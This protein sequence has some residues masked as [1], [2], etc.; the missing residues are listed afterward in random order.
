MPPE[1]RAEEY[2]TLLQ[3]FELLSRLNEDKVLN[4]CVFAERR[5]PPLGSC[6]EQILDAIRTRHAI[7]FDYECFR[8]NNDLKKE[9]LEPHLLKESQHRWYV[10]GYDYKARLR[11]FALERIKGIVLSARKFEPKPTEQIV[12]IFDNSFGIWADENIPIEDIVV[13]YSKLDGSFVKS[14][15]LHH[16]Q[17]VI[18]EEEGNTTI[19]FR[20]RITNDFVMELLSRSRSVEIIEPRWLRAEFEKIYRNALRRNTTEL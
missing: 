18:A 5:R 3:S 17:H 7:E 8:D 15:P 9:Y 1:S 10:V 12:R 20:L 2:E 6:F 14:A 11:T 19:G 16:S 4:K 13:R